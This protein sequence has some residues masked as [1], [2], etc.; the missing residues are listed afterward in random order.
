[1]TLRVIAVYAALTP[2]ALI[3]GAVA[4]LH[5][6]R[7]P[8]EALVAMTVFTAVMGALAACALLIRRRMS[9]MA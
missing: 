7:N 5:V 1:M 8:E 2:F 9:V 6:L 4:M 3:G